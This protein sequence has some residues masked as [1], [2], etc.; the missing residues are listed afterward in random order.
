MQPLT[1]LIILLGWG[2]KWRGS[3]SPEI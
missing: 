1:L 2:L 3:L